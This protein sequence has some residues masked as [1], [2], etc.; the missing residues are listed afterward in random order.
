MFTS[1]KN[2][3]NYYVSGELGYFEME[4]IKAEIIKFKKYSDYVMNNNLY[5]NFR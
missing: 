2:S 5:K 1:L 4:R 3:T